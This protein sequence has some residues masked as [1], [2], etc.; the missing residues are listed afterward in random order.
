MAL[1]VER[2]P[3]N[4]GMDMLKITGFS[5]GE[6]HELKSME[7]KEAFDKVIEMLDGRN[8]GAGTCYVRGNGVYGLWFDEEAAYLSIGNSAD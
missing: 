5:D 7:H 4:S 6:L 2:M 8:D 3:M 1:Y